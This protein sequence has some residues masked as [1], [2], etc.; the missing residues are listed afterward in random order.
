V[1]D[2]T[3]GLP[4]VF[5]YHSVEEYQE[6][7]FLVTVTPDR[8]ERQMRWLRARGLRGV[9]MRELLA[10]RRADRADRLVGLTFDDGYQDFAG[11][12]LPVLDRFRFT[13]T[14][15]VVAGRFGGHNAWETH[16]PRKSLVTEAQTR[17]LAF[18]GVEIGSHSLHHLKLSSLDPD[19]LDAEVRQ[20]RAVLADIIGEPVAGFCYPYGDLSEH[21]VDVVRASGYEYACSVGSTGQDGVFAL[22][23][24]YVGDRDNGPRLTAKR[25][26]HRVLAGRS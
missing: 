9:S 16:G 4:L 7:P 13:A 18:A 1:S 26:R 3:R 11:N 24:V 6:D 23:R 14:V 12:V 10:A 19:A 2:G 8:F 5:M 21:V 22:P 20:S 15:F 25:L 17:E